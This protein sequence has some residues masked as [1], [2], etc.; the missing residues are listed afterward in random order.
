MPGPL[1]GIRVV[2]LSS[3]FGAYAGKLLADMGAR[4]ILVEPP[5]GDA[6]RAYPPFVQDT[7]DPERS[8]WFWHYNRV[9]TATGCSFCSMTPTSSSTP[10]LRPG[11]KDSDSTMTT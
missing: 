1:D 2:E 8:L 7:P 4:V 3:E 10:N 9:P 6:T 5:D 11:W